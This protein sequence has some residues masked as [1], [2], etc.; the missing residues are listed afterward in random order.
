MAKVLDVTAD[1]YETI[2]QT[3]LQRI[4]IKH[5]WITEPIFQASGIIKQMPFFDWLSQLKSPLEFK[6]AAV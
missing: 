2:D 6:P 5:S 3:E 4:R 1:V